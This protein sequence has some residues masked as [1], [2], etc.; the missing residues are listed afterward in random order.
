MKKNTS[1]KGLVSYFPKTSLKL[2]L[3]YFFLI[4]SFFQSHA[5]SYTQNT[6][7]TLDMKEV[8]IKSVLNEI[9]RKTDYKFLYEKDIFKTDEVVDISVKKERL[10][11]VLNILLRKFD[12]SIEYLDKQI[13]ISKTR[14]D[15]IVTRNKPVVKN[16]PQQQITGQVTYEDGYPLPGASVSIKGTTIGTVTNFDGEYTI[17][18]KEGQTLVFNYL[19][20]KTEEK[21]VYSSTGRIDVVLFTDDSILEEIVVVAYGVQSKKSLV[22]S[23]SSITSETI[24]NQQ[25]TSP[26][27]AIQGAVPG[28]NI[29]TSGGQ[30]G[31]NPDIRI[32]GF[33][34][35]NAAQAPLIVVDGAAFNGN[36]NTISQDQIESISVLK[37]ASSTS[38]YG[39]RGANGVILITTKKGRK[40]TAPSITFRSQI[41]FSNPAV[42][43]HDLLGTED[44]MKL[45]WE[46]LKNTNQYVN[47]QTPSIAAQNA[48]AQL[49]DHLGYNPY[50]VSNPIDSD[51]N[52]V[53]GANLLWETDW[54]KEVI[55][56]DV[57]RTNH[58]LNLSGGSKKSTY[59]MSVD[60]LNEEGSVISSDFERISARLN[61][62]S[63]VTDWLNVGLNTSFSRSNS[64]NPD[65]T[66]NSVVQA[67]SWIY[68]VSGIY[69]VYARDAEGNFHRDTT[70]NLVYDLG[71]GYV[72][73]QP[74]NSVRSARGG[75][76]ILSYIL[77]GK[78]QRKRTNYLG[79]AFAEIKIVDGLKF[80]TQFSY[81]NY[82]FDSFSFTDDLFGFASNVGGRV[83]QSR[84]ITSTVNAVQSL[85]YKK[86]FGNHHISVDAITEAYTYELDWLSASGTGFLPDIT[87][88]DGSTTP[89]SVSG[90][91]E[92]ERLN[93]YMGR[94]AYNF[95]QKYFTEFSARSDGST[96][97]LD[98]RWGNFFSAGA[99]WIVSNENFLSDSNTIS[100]LKFRG[101]YGEL[102]NN[103]GIGLFP[104][105][106]TYIAGW[107][108]EGNN[109]VLLDG[110]ADPFIS[111][112]KTA[113]SN[114]G[115]DF[116]LFNGKI[117]GIVDY[118]S[119]ESV[120]L[121][122]NKPITP[123]AGV[124]N[125]TTNVGAI[126]NSGWEITLNSTNV[127][128]DNV[129][130]T[131][132]I[133]FSLNKNEI[134][135]LTQDEFISG[136]KLWK[137]GNSLFD[138]YIPEWAGVDPDD[139]FGMWYMDVLDD[140]GN[141]I[142]KVTTK[143]YEEA[144]RYNNG[145]ALPDV[146]G[147]F[148][149]FL[150][151]KQ[152]DLNILT[153]FSFGGK[154]LDTDYASIMMG[155][156]NSPGASAH[157]D[158]LNRW[159]KPGDI[160]DTPLLLASNN[161]HSYQS[162]RFLFKNDF[163]RLK[164]LT[165]GYNFHQAVLERMGCNRLRLF[166]QADNVF[167]WQS[168]KG[169]DPEQSFDGTTSN[170]SPLS[171]T[172]TGGLIVEF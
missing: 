112:E 149:S 79:N 159:Q 6:I 104:Y 166:L 163:A 99:S 24:S 29:L 89:E 154:L 12:V 131:T 164:S 113:S 55:R 134:T 52:L 49:V 60:Y 141:V 50:S 5:N 110:V 32:R 103:R 127:N 172:I 43:I 144:T 94:V 54:E 3:T 87:N 138:F 147:G 78:E 128:T 80:K 109:G 170:R 73:G 116:E 30:P 85:N 119:K 59:F 74:V 96:R 62:E 64:G 167:T 91:T 145:S 36:L 165:L 92:T 150:R 45:T 169:I 71:S 10:S 81:E 126:K 136:T 83:S 158:N 33:G 135:E 47:A 27:R 41:G 66:S 157:P 120:D 142:D 97:F 46:A 17:E 38:L 44:Y 42:G 101:S 93:S 26:V 77:L 156:F 125:V 72:T 82:L 57:L 151:I 111:W 75:E 106:S 121:I 129:T 114:L 20:M 14:Y 139:G 102:G 9:E 118:Y 4:V 95:D 162:T 18:A 130:W 11:T 132:G 108:N 40:E 15:N 155:S 152:F 39:S 161:S 51:G 168:H 146:T 28:V 7:I 69:P 23:V 56:R 35:I 84:N 107:N 58:N 86:T 16:E 76:N 137:E 13:I 160:T 65:Q 153:N 105:Q 68:G 70:G 88:L 124:E 122:Y 140:D 1:G 37:D 100:L 148:T 8:T 63:Q 115:V 117:S 98:E 19:G 133:N 53:S 48:S 67:I 34:S 171:K 123:S 61:L 90:N 21:R 2:K 22:G 31:N 143:D 25:V